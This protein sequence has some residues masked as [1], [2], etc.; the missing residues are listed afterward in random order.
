MMSIQFVLVIDDFSVK[1]ARQ[2][3]VWHLV[4]ILSEHYIISENWTGDKFI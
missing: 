1:Y 2:E 3:H 4:N